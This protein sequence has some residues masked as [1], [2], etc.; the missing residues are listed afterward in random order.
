MNKMKGLFFFAMLTLSAVAF[1]QSNEK[2]V[3]K[4]VKGTVLTDTDLG[5]LSMVSNAT[6]AASRGGATIQVT[7]GGK[8]Y[9]I[10]QKLS[11]A[12]AIAI[13]K[14]IKEF[15]KTSPGEKNPAR[16]T[17][18]SRGGLCYYW[19][20]YCDGYGYCWWYKYWYYC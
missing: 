3:S 20:Y 9:K 16:G 1:G 14:A 10:R 15:R 8:A 2:T 4:I 19:Y 11:S 13:T 6:L 7:I 5:F 18:T 17:E 12:D